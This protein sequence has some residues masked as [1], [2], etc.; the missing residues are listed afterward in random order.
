MSKKRRIWKMVEIACLFS[1]ILMG[2]TTIFVPLIMV[3]EIENGSS[4]A[5]MLWM[6]SIIAG[7]FGIVS[8]VSILIILRLVRER[9][10]VYSDCGRFRAETRIRYKEV[11]TLQTETQ[12]QLDEAIVKN[13]ELTRWKD[14]AIQ[15]VPDLRTRVS[16]YTAKELAR[17]FMDRFSDIE[18][19]K[20][21]KKTFVYLD[22]VIT[23]YNDLPPEVKAFV[24]YNMEKVNKEC[25]K[26]RIQYKK[27]AE[28]YLDEILTKSEEDSDYEGKCL[29]AMAFFESLRPTVRYQLSEQAINELRMKCFEIT[30]KYTYPRINRQYA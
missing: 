14:C 12:N 22:R 1:L 7:A 24:T 10:R 11:S 26:A 8:T 13:A 28:S 9:H 30:L 25:I 6:Y 5:T 21:S 17:E 16:G 27:A 2:F 18:S 29:D 23:A 4:Y 3:K 19:V 15:L 20:G